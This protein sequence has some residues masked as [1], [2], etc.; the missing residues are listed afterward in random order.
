MPLPA[1]QAF[2]DVLSGDISAIIDTVIATA[3]TLRPQM[4]PMMSL[5]TKRSIPKGSNQIDIPFQ[6]A[7]LSPN[8]LTEGDE[9]P[10]V[11]D[12]SLDNISITPSMLEITY[13]IHRR[14]FSFGLEDISVIAGKEL[15]RAQAQRFET[16]LLNLLDD[17][18]TLT[19]GG[20]AGDGM[21]FDDLMQSKRDLQANAVNQGGP[22]PEPVY[23]VMS[24][25]Q[26]YDL[27]V[28]LGARGVAAVTDNN[29]GGFTPG[30]TE[31]LIRQYGVA[32][33]SLVGV[34]MFWSGYLT[35]ANVATTGGGMFSR[36]ALILAVS[37]DWDFKIFEESAWPGL[38]FR[39]I[40]DYGTRVGPFPQWIV[41]FSL[42]VE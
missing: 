31:D 27:A 23:A 8:S 40:A 25:L 24:S 11:Q 2:G 7:I 17:T 3:E 14:A 41:T 1:T 9:I 38:I 32:G 33:S 19:Q 22:A 30:L 5:V 4:A 37:D 35:D 29:L 6:D 21:E 16:D 12:F 15:A 42:N 36:D 26:Q 20:G 10:G 34:P 13:R 39:A 18:G 28:D